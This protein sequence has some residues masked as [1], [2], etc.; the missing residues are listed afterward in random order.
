MQ[1]G[2]GSHALAPPT[3]SK[4]EGH[5]ALDPTRPQPADP[6]LRRLSVPAGGSTAARPDAEELPSSPHQTPPSPSP[7]LSTP[8]WSSP[9]N[10]SPVNHDSNVALDGEKATVVTH[11][12]GDAASLEP[13][14]KGAVDAAPKSLPVDAR[15]NASLN[16]VTG[17]EVNKVLCVS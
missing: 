9:S 10:R 12:A 16:T 4:P 7:V 13:R 8:T 3:L 1:A 2:G 14:L 17:Q 5:D 11:A 6:A 15:Q